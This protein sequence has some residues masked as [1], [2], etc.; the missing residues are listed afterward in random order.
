MEKTNQKGRYTFNFNAQNMASGM[1]IY[2]LVAENTIILIATIVVV[3]QS[4]FPSSPAQAPIDGGLGL[5]AA[6]C[7]AYAWKRLKQRGKD[8]Y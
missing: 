8:C 2:L 7:G 1:C 4:G 5:L 6:A 3:A